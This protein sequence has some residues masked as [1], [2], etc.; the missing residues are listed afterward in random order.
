MSLRAQ[1]F[2]LNVAVAIFEI[3][4]L[5]PG[6]AL[7]RLVRAAL[8]CHLRR[9]LAHGQD[10]NCLLLFG[11]GMMARRVHAHIKLCR[12]L[13]RPDF[14]EACRI[15]RASFLLITRCEFKSA[16]AS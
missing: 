10:R 6:L 8:E 13:K 15:D 12:Y 9:D 11:Y 3:F 16:T 14:S 2:R 5:S 1:A 7:R 4:M